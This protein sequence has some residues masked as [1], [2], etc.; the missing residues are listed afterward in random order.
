[1]SLEDLLGVSVSVASRL[2]E[3][4]TQAPSSVTVFTRAEILRLG[5]RSLEELLNYAPGIYSARAGSSA[6]AVSVR[7]KTSSQLSNDVLFL[8][9]GQRLNDDFSN[10]ALLFNR[11]LSIGNVEQVEVVRGPGSALYGSDALLGV[12]N[13]VTADDLNEAF[14]GGGSAH[15]REGLASLSADLGPGHAS[16]FFHLMDDEGEAFTDPADP[17]G[18]RLRDPRESLTVQASLDTGGSR[19]EAR[20]ARFELDDFYLFSV[21]PSDESNYYRSSD[22]WL[23]LSHRLWE[24]EAGELTGSARYRII[25]HESLARPLPGEVME[26]LNAVGW[27]RGTRDYLA[28]AVVEQRETTLALDGRYDLS[29]RQTLVAGVEYRHTRFDKTLNQNNYESA[30]VARFLP[31][32]EGLLGGET[33]LPARCDYARIRYYGRVRETTDF[34][35]TGDA[36]EVLGLY[37]QDKIDLTPS[38]Q[39]TV[40]LRLDHYSDFGT[41]LNPRA[42]L[43]WSG[44]PGT[45]LKLMYG[46]AFRAPT[47]SELQLRNTPDIVGNPD[48]KPEKSRTL[49]LAWLQ[50]LGAVQTTL[51]GYYT[52]F[53]D[54]IQRSALAGPFDARPSFENRGTLELSGV[55]L[56]ARAEIAEGL[57]L[58]GAYS[59]AFELAEDPRTVPRDLASLSLNYR[60]GGLNLN[61]NGI[62]RGSAHSGAHPP[63]ELDGHWIANANL[64]YRL[65][66][67]TLVGGVYNLLDEEYFT[68]TT[69]PL[70]D[71]MLNRGR[72]YRLGLELDL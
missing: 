36:R 35:A 13:I 54:R 33:E 38:L 42:A 1:M 25:D 23:S 50:D 49:E 32:I 65:G 43:V 64:R 69:T 22:A 31:C 52:R 56:E 5:V 47:V 8:I 7:G 60:R 11:L 51:T 55:E 58:R 68:Y 6:Y 66:G 63:A 37:L 70:P 27:T 30:D 24:G 41:T 28:G 20:Y 4:F 21:V 67:V 15:R 2:R 39:A 26:V 12:V 44:K 17:E 61:L 59:H 72:E 10:A 19:L 71:G 18:G 16:L 53:P 40:G 57:G 46:E 62:Y 9:N 14:A 48:L 45:V 29:E 3:N 34:A